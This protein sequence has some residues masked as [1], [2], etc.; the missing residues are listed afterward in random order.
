MFKRLRR[1]YYRPLM[2]GNIAFAVRA[3]P[4][5]ANSHPELVCKKQKMRLSQVTEKLESVAVH[6]LRLLP[7]TK[8]CHEFLLIIAKWCPKL[9]QVV[10]RNW[11]T[12]MNVANGLLV[13]HCL[14]IWST[15]EGALTQ[16]TVIRLE[17]LPE[18]MQSSAGRQQFHVRLPP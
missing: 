2:D 6:L 10:P 18:Q 7:C 11:T 15:E 9:T 8:L 16:R 13:S 14:H 12:S 17:A 5:C 3:C 1:T 4:N